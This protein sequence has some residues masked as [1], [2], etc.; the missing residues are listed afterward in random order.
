MKDIVC[1][2][3][4]Q[5]D[6]DMNET[7]IDMIET[8]E[9]DLEQSLMVELEAQEELSGLAYGLYESV[10]VGS[11]NI[12][13]TD[14]NRERYELVRD[15]LVGSEVDIVGLQ[16]VLNPELLSQILESVFPYYHSTRTKKGDYLMLFSKFPIVGRDPYMNRVVGYRNGLDYL[17]QTVVDVNGKQLCFYNVHLA[18]G[19][20]E[21]ERLHQVETLDYLSEKSFHD[22]NIVHVALGDFNALP[23]ARSIRFLKGLDVNKYGTV[24]TLWVDAGET[25]GLFTTAHSVNQLG[26]Q[27]AMRNGIL[28]PEFIPNRRIDYIFVKGF[29]YGRIGSPVLFRYLYDNRLEAV[30]DHNGIMCELLL[31]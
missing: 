21:A 17:L 15:I 29:S 5:W 3:F 2:V 28:H 4:E 9:T 26:V 27:S 10:K 18:W 16:E 1:D 24:S 19:G 22:E 31:D 7:M 23:E 20:K 6:D 14:D 12:L 30:S 25:D 11:W 13:G 8:N